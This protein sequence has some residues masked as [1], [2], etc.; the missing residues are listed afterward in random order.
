MRTTFEAI[1]CD[2]CF[3]GL[4]LCAAIT[5]MCLALQMRTQICTAFTVVSFEAGDTIVQQGDIADAF[6]VVCLGSVE[7]SIDGQKPSWG[8]KLGAGSG[9]AAGASFGE[10]GLAQQGVSYCSHLLMRLTST[11]AAADN[12]G[13]GLA[14]AGK[15]ERDNQGN[16]PGCA[17][18]AGCNRL[19]KMC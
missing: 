17:R 6:Y 1:T 8:G 15:K 12:G 5:D 19:H 3:S 13:I 2:P 11:V 7:V 16:Y 9:A 4:P 14:V 10:L 18:E